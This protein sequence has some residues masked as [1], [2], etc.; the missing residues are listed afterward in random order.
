M[1]KYGFGRH[2]W[3]VTLVQLESYL[4]VGTTTSHPIGAISNALDCIACY[5]FSG[6]LCLG[7]RLYQ[8]LDYSPVCYNGALAS[9]LCIDAC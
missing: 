6:N 3:E 2:L 1:M 4:N 9:F 8:A 7:T 5:P